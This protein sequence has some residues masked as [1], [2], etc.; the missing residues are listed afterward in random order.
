MPEKQMQSLETMEKDELMQHI[1]SC[2]FMM[3]D[4]ALYL[5]THPTDQE[6]LAHFIEHRDMYN[7]YMDAFSARYGALRKAQ[8]RSADGW[9]SWSNTPWPWEKEAN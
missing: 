1:R 7:K 4:L 2:S 5:D 8:V 6:A 9:A 3:M